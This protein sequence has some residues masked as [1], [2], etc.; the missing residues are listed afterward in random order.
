MTLRQAAFLVASEEVGKARDFEW[1]VFCN[2]KLPRRALKKARL[3]V[4]AAQ[5]RANRI[6]STHPSQLPDVLRV[7]IEAKARA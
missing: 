5:M 7:A 6:L 4:H 2:P 1:L 3:A